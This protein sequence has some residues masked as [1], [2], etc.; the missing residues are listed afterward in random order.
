[1]DVYVNKVEKVEYPPQPFHPADVYPELT[2]LLYEPI[3]SDR[4]EIYESVRRIFEHLG[5]DKRNQGSVRWN[6][7]KDYVKPGQKV[8]IK[9]NLVRGEHPYG[10]DYVESM[11]SNASIIRPLVDYILLATG[12][13]VSIKIGDVPLQD[14][15]WEDAIRKSGLKDLTDFY[16]EKDIRIELIDMR[17]EIAHVNKYDIIDKRIKNPVR[18]REMYKS[19]DLGNRSELID[20]IDNSSRFEITDYGKGTVQK[21]H[22]RVKNEYFIPSE[23]LEA[24]L[25]INVPKLKTHR[26]AGYTCAMKNL[27][28]INGD[29]SWIA[30]HTRG[31]KGKNGDE[32]NTHISIKKL[33]EVRIWNQ[34]KLTKTGIVAASFLKMFFMRYIWQ[35]KTYKQVS[36]EGKDT[37]NFFE[38]SW[39]GNDTLW[40]C[41][42]DLNKIIFYADKNGILQDKKQ[43]KYLCIV[44]AV[45]AGQ[46]EGPM[47]QQPKPLGVV[48]GGVNPVYIDYVAAQLMKYNYLE[49]PTIY[50]GFENRWWNLVDKSPKEIEIG[51]NKPLEEIA[52]YFEPTV[53]WKG[54]LN[55]TPICS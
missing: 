35:G 45:W 11:I 28:G 23:V 51:S 14:C 6:P 9:P 47:E 49:L 53:G 8:L 19:V 38:G 32:F 2:R 5:F 39:Y 21:H 29:K 10:D 40:R 37:Q 44:D 17:F 36:A 7:L 26:K 24:D 54:R 46:K 50:H 4:N 27:I 52:S 48:V 15:K 33:L 12:G 1:M 43:R 22:N 55:E 41:I 42:K 16:R 34:L 31:I 18:T 20:I 25:F 30:H 13:D 3:V